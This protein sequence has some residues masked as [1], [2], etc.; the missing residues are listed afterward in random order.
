[1]QKK[2]TLFRILLSVA[3]VAAFCVSGQ[4]AAQSIKNITLDKTYGTLEP[5]LAAVGAGETLEIRAS[6]TYECRGLAIGKDNVTLRGAAGVKAVLNCDFGKEYCLEITG[7]GVTIQNLEIGRATK[8]ISIKNARNITLSDL[9][10][11]NINSDGI[12]AENVTGLTIDTVTF[13]Q[14]N[15]GGISVDNSDGV[16]IDT[17]VA[18][19]YTS[20]RNCILITGTKNLVIGH[21]VLGA[22]GASIDL[23][24]CPSPRITSVAMVYGNNGLNLTNCPGALVDGLTSEKITNTSDVNIVS[25]DNCVIQNG[26]LKPRNKIAVQVSSSSGVSILNMR[27]LCTKGQTGGISLDQ[28]PNAI[29]RY[30]EIRD[31]G[32]S[33]AITMNNSTGGILENN[34]ICS[35]EHAGIQIKNNNDNTLIKNNT[36]LNNNDSGII[37]DSNNK[38]LNIRNNI[39][40]IKLEKRCGMPE[41]NNTGAFSHL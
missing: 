14:I 24:G 17:I 28:S 18:T 30:C 15:R 20:I 9:R 31:A 29:V 4:A 23:T 16:S 26:T 8:G 22:S 6:G 21:S 27:L 41:W 25:S 33:D 37:L 13:Y 39:V 35:G 10:I 19:N 36:I 40:A 38:N 7:N 5:A 2:S 32:Q 11:N 12:H 3:V 34:L 1:M